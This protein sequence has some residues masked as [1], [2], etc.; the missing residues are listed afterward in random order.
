MPEVVAWQ[1]LLY[2][3]LYKPI[4][5]SKLNMAFTVSKHGLYGS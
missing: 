5:L 1:G 2:L 4:P 3:F